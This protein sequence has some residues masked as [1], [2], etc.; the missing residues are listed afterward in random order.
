MW[1]EILAFFHVVGIVIQLFL[2][3]IIFGAFIY[4]VYDNY[5][6]E[7]KHNK[8]KMKNPARGFLED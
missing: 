3:L 8:E 7:K 5:K 4:M 1:L 6:W 2:G